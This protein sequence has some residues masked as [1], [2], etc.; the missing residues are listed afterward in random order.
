MRS[1]SASRGFARCRKFNFHTEVTFQFKETVALA[2]GY[3]LRKP[4]FSKAYELV[5]VAED[6]GTS[7]TFRGPDFD[8]SGYDTFL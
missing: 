8:G 1:A 4:Y 2:P 5:K 6:K 3:Q 7:I